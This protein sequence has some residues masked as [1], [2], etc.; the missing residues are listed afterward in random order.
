MP[1]CKR[2]FINEVEVK[3]HIDHHMSPNFRNRKSNSTNHLNQV[4]LQN[5][6]TTAVTS[7]ATSIVQQTPAAFFKPDFYFAQCYGQQFLN[8]SYNTQTFANLQNTTTVQII[9]NIADISKLNI[10]TVTTANNM[11]AA[12]VLNIP[13][14][15]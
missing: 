2:R 6:R 7:C 1:A 4:Q 5:N 3:K 11:A 8:N 13:N 12:T 14:S 9:S 10:D 15:S